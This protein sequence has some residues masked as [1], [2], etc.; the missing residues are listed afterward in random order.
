[1]LETNSRDKDEVIDKKSFTYISIVIP[2]YNDP[3]GFRDT[4]DSLINQDYPA[5]SF[6]IVVADNGSIDET[7]AAI[8]EYINRYPSLVRL[9]VEDKIQSSYAARNKGIESSK[10]S[11]IA[12][13]DADMSVKN[14]WLTKIDQ[15]F[16]E[17]R[18][19]YLGCAVEISLKSRSIYEMYNK[20]TGFPVRKYIHEGHYAPTCCLVVRKEVFE[21]IGLFDSRLISSGD[22]EF[23]IRVY[24]SKRKIHFDPTIV[25]SH[26]ARSSFK[27]LTNKYFRIGRGNFQLITYHQDAFEELRRKYTNPLYYMPNIPW[28]ISMQMN[29][30]VIWVRLS[31]IE[32]IK[33][34]LID[35]L[36][37]LAKNMG[38]FYEKLNHENKTH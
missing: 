17:Y 1:M 7:P 19:D 3:Y 35:W 36:L 38:Y 8:R 5:D 2:V 26:P 9:A 34:F 12:F 27:S 18:W 31:F 37:R 14:D 32:K 21:E 20:M 22:K 10:G 33:I 29:K 15:S 16:K 6:E 25:M 30:N 11:L 4:L 23:G 13:I 24:E 28:I